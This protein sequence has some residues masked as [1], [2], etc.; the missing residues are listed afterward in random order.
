MQEPNV[1]DYFVVRTTGLAAR[2]I[3]IGTFSK[4]NHAGI[5]MGHG[6]IIEARP[7]GVTI[8]PI[9]KYA[10]NKIIWN[11]NHDTS[12]TAHERDKLSYYARRFV[13]EKYG[14]W[15]IAALAFR[16]LG[17]GLLPLDALAEREDRVICSQLVAWCYSRAGIKLTNKP[18]ALVTP[19]DLAKRLS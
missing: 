9:T 2:L 18:H 1:G 4:W 15:S 5:Y 11:T 14:T 16:C 7:T 10:N 6:Q 17:V 12:L 3:Q 13:G 8:S 19:K